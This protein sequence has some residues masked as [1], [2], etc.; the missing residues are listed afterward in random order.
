M[1]E[2]VMKAAERDEVRE[3]RL[4]AVGPL[5]H[6]VAVHVSLEAATRETAAIVA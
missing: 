4:A 6:V 3:L 2:P 1:H 5:L